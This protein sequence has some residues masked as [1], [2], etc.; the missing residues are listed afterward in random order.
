MAR[1]KLLWIMAPLILTSCTLASLFI[2]QADYF[3]SKKISSSLDLNSEQRQELKK[4]LAGWLNAIKPQA[5]ILVQKIQ[6]YQQ[7]I[8]QKDLPLTYVEQEADSLV[9]ILL[10]TA[11][12]LAP[13]LAKPLSKMNKEQWDHFWKEWEK[14]N[15]KLHRSNRKLDP[16]YPFDKYQEYFGKLSPDQEEYFRAHLKSF[17]LRNKLQLERRIEFQRKL[18]EGIAQKWSEQKISQF[19]LQYQR[20]SLQSSVELYGKITAKLLAS[21]DDKQR[22]HFQ[23]KLAA[24]NKVLKSYLRTE[25]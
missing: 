18:Q 1:N 10:A 21:L 17:L 20:A 22:L 23:D 11:E 3:L 2:G 16:N 12:E 8:E 9:Q 4:D 7:R 19:I 5:K 6:D 15:R 14:F 25:Y 13:I 24:I